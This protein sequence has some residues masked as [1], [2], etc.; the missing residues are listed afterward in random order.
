M[1]GIFITFFFMI[2]II[3]FSEFPCIDRKVVAT[4][5]G[6]PEKKTFIFVGFLFY[7]ESVIICP[8]S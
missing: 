7:L 4:W 6:F 1:A 2:F 3:L 5:A 8:K